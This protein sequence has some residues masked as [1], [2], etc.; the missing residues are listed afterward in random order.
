VG[1]EEQGERLPAELRDPIPD[2]PLDL[3]GR[4]TLV[5]GVADE[6]EQLVGQGSQGRGVVGLGVVCDHE[7]RSSRWGNV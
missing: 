4:A 7:G 5:G 1:P 6:P 3:V 2:G